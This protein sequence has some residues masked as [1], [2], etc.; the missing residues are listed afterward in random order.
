MNHLLRWKF[1]DDWW[2]SHEFS[3]DL[4]RKMIYDNW[5][6]LIEKNSV[7]FFNTV[8]DKNEMFNELISGM[9]RLKKNRK[10]I[11]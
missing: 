7:I 10:E 8:D 11:R 6:M 9:K 5:D 2:N 4:G 3:R 1:N